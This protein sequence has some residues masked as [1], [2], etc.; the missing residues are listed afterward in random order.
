VVAVKLR[1]GDASAGR[2]ECNCNH[3]VNPANWPCRSGASCP[4][5]LQLAHMIITHT[6]EAVC[7]LYETHTFEAVCMLY[8]THTFEAVCMLYETHTLE[9]V[10]MLYQTWQTSAFQGELANTP[11]ERRLYTV[12]NTSV[13]SLHVKSR[14]VWTYP[15]LTTSASVLACQQ[16][17]SVDLPCFDNLSCGA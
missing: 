11:V 13:C 2:A 8:E 12:L 4:F 6:F 14:G 7:M 15:A 5:L 17:R 1:G 3:V 10:C 9:A 16:Q